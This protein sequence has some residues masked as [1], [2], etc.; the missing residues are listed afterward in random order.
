MLDPV[1]LA[2]EL[3][4]CPSVTPKDEGTLSVLE[5]AL[6]PLG[7]ACERLVYGDTANLF[8]RIGDEGPQFCFAG[9][10]DVVP[11]GDAK[12]WRHDPFGG[13]IENGVL[14]G[15]GAAD[16]KGA[17]AAFA[18]AAARRLAKGPLKGSIALLITGDEEG[19]A[20]NGTQKVL[21]WLKEKAITLDHCVVGEPSSVAAVGDQ[22]KVGRRGS[23]NF[24]IT[25][26]G[27][28]GHVAYPDKSLNPIP[29]LAEFVTRLT[30]LKLDDGNQFFQPSTLSFT[31]VDVGNPASNVI[32]A[33]ARARFNI[34]FNNKHSGKSLA[35]MIVDLAVELAMKTGCTFMVDDDI[36]GEAFLTEPGPFLT[37]V[38]DAV[39]GVT[40][41]APTSSTGGGTSDARFIKDVCPVVELGLVNATMHKAN[42]CVPLADL[43]KLTEIYAAILDSYFSAPPK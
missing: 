23:I 3:I 31:S 26:T 2:Q 8:A 38:E 35:R 21:A 41:C 4:R 39:E 24:K 22:V 25:A 11:P 7:F 12:L 18:A 6:K 42:E 32:P 5:D 19:D 40:G 20:V 10:T 1:V 43:E 27:S 9:H 30:N 28:Q 16:M 37:L 14:H 36:S 29:A 15:R 17:V 34:R 33:E 13:V